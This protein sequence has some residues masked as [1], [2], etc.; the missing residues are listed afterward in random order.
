LVRN[1]MVDQTEGKRLDGSHVV[2]GEAHFFGPAQ[3]D[4][5]RKRHREAPARHDAD[6]GMSVREAGPLR[7]HQEIAPERDL[8]PARHRW[9][10]DGADNRFRHDRKR[11]G[12][13]ALGVR[14]GRSGAEIAR[15]RTQF[16]EIE[17]GAERRIGARQHHSLHP[18][19][20]VRRHQRLGERRQ[21]G[22]V[23]GVTGLRSVEG[24]GGDSASE[25]AADDRRGVHLW[26]SE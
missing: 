22:A 13:Q 4:G 9:T 18:L 11:C 19:V 2:T 25:L 3:A 20:L 5:L 7:C 12:R 14:L 1:D 17:A 24:D 10:I 6:P 26:T 23:E 21:Q 8:E 15:R 16:L